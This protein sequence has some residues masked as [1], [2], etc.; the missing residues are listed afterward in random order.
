MA[1]ESKTSPRL[2]E[3]LASLTADG[4][5]VF[6][7]ECR[8]ILWNAAM[9]KLSGLRGEELLG[10][11]AFSVLPFLVENGEDQLFHMVLE[12]HSVVSKDRP[13]RVEGTRRS[14]YYDARYS[15]WLGPSGQVLGGVAF[16]RDVTES[17]LAAERMKESEQR[18]EN[19]AD[20]APVLLWMSGTD[21]LCTF[22]NHTW[23]AFTGRTLADEWGVGWAESVHFED[24]QRCMDT[25]VAA[26]N[27]REVFEMEYRLR[28]HDG[29]Y[30][31]I[32]DRGRPR[33]TPDGTFAGF[34]G[35]CVDITER[36]ELESELRRAVRARDEF[37]SIASHELRTPITALQLNLESLVRA[38]HGSG[39]S[40][41][42]FSRIGKHASRSLEKTAHLTVMVNTLLDVSRLESGGLSLQRETIELGLLVRGVVDRHQE[43][44]AE[45]GCAL[46]VSLQPELRGSWDRFRIEQVVGNLL[47]NALK[48]GVGKPVDVTVA[49]TTGGVKLVVADNGIGI[50]PEDQPKVFERFARFVPARNYGGFGLGLWISRE[51]VLAHRGTIHLESALGRG[52]T[53]VVELPGADGARP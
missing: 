22:F 10:K 28:R 7:R 52:T 49:A 45:A 41:D 8:F 21:G 38:M 34:I 18:F 53:F 13:F 25:Y 40:D 20:A 50:A 15:P 33:Y 30:R 3:T 17:K 43:A 42:R 31:W 6:D 5:F 29:V 35:S 39:P 14:G 48:Y 32:L 11:Q 44:A 37:L 9:E 16:I 19:M 2:L 1:L 24:F 26:F 51:I 47:A 36:K 27:A 4:L 23:L 46:N 12:G